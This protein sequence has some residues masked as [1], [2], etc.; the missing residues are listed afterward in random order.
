MWRRLV[1]P[2]LARLVEALRMHTDAYI[3]LH[4]CGAIT[5]L[6]D[7]LVEVGIQVIN[8]VQVS[9]R[10]MDPAELKRRYGERL[11]FWGGI[12]THR[13]MPSGTPNQ[14]CQAVHETAAI[15][16]HNGG[17]I[18]AAVHNLQPGVPPE[19]IIAL[20]TTGLALNNIFSKD[21]RR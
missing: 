4:S 2:R 9:A 20:Y 10:G 19:N 12:D 13:L 17:Y 8:P 5:P 3:G 18:L 11:S 21:R 7:D 14:V 1:K 6:L 15:L 16:G